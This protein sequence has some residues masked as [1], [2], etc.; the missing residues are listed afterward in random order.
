MFRQIAQGGPSGIMPAAGAPE[1]RSAY[2]A[3]AREFQHGK[4]GRAEVSA[5]EWRWAACHAQEQP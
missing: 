3:A 5:P 4:V 1:L 2:R